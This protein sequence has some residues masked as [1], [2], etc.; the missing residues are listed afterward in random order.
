MIQSGSYKGIK[1]RIRGVYKDYIEVCILNNGTIVNV[2]RGSMVA[3]NEGSV[4]AASRKHRSR[5]ISIDS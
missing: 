4:S 5:S 3:R 2:Q 1:G